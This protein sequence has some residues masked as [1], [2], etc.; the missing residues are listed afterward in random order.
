MRHESLKF[1]EQMVND[2]IYLACRYVRHAKIDPYLITIS[3]ANTRLSLSNVIKQTIIN[4]F[5]ENPEGVT[6]HTGY[7]SELFESF[8]TSA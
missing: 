3:L 4:K 8:V 6:S 1:I 7:L 2:L 5:R